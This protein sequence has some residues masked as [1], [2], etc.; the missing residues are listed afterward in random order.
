MKRTLA[1]SVLLC[2]S[3]APAAAQTELGPPVRV[4]LFSDASY[5]W[6]ERDVR[7]GFSLHQVVGHL[8]AAL[9]DRLTVAVEATVDPRSSAATL[10]R[11]ILAY[12]VSDALKLS[13][14]RYHTPISWWNTQYHHGLW[15][16]TPIDR[17]RTVRFG[18][19]LIP[20]HFLGL[21]ATGTVPV[22]RSTLVYEAGL[23]NGREPGLVGPG[24]GGEADASAAGVAGVRFRPAA[25]PG[26]ELGVHGYLDEV[27]PDGVIG[28]TRER[29]LGGHVVWLANPEVV[30]EYLHF[31]HD[32]EAAG[33]EPVGSDAYYAQVGWKLPP[34]PA[35]QPY[36]RYETV[37][38]GEGD[39]LFSG[40]GLGYD[41]VIGGVRWDF[42]AF[43]ALKGEV[44]WEEFAGAD[45]V[46]SV[47]LN[48]SFV[49]PNLIE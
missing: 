33:T 29:I 31:T 27:D 26:L 13:V 16:Q 21:L 15:L 32:P 7:Q 46:T 34:A 3:F 4:M 43:A 49:I 2:A 1:A 23:G 38:V 8:N 20:V 45:R 6:T 24:D 14:G 10:E 35:V 19:P 17:P 37:D 25:V 48:A 44:R 12:D 5:E 18:T 9:S 47:V 22:G 40:L 30:V 36:V 42:A 39:P 28:P 11:M 41:G